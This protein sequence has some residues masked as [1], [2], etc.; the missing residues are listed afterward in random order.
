VARQ[1]SAKAPTAVRIRSEPRIM[2][3]SQWLGILAALALV[4]ACFLPWTYHP[5]LNQE[6]TGF[7]SEQNVYGKPGKVF[8][9]LALV[10]IVFFLLPR[11]WAKRWNLIATGLVAAYAIK[12][13]LMFAGC[14]RGICPEKRAGL[15]IMLVSGIVMLVMAI[16]PDIKLKGK[17]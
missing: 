14:Y 13:F 16:L 1:S 8:I 11:I 9:F 7:F 4:G 5:D 10:A 17:A 12:T 6:F 15:W 2:K 3:Y